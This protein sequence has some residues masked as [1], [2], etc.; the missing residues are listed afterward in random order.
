MQQISDRVRQSADCVTKLWTQ[1]E[2]IG[3][4]IGAIEEI[5]DQTNLLAL[6]AA[7]EAARAGDQGRGFAVVADEVRVLATRTTKATKDIGEMIGAIQKEIKEAVAG[8]TLGVDEASRG[9]EEASKSGAALEDILSQIETITGQINQIA[10]SAEEQSAT[11]TGVSAILQ[12]I[13]HAVGETAQG[14]QLSSDA[15][16]NLAKIAEDLQERVHYFN[17]AC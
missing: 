12:Q 2:Q 6:N 11:T 13:N 17:L 1:S 4:I 16:G 9:T 3:E 7:I 10:T 15:A 14:V 5:A 8:M